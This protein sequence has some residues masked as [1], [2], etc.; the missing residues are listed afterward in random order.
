MA[1]GKLSAGLAHELNNPAAAARRAAQQL[2]ENLRS[3]NGL[4]LTLNHRTLSPEQIAFLTEFQHEA[5]ECLTAAPALD[6]L[7]ESEREEKI[8]SWMDAH[9]VEDGWEIAPTFVRAGMDLEKLNQFADRLGG[10]ALND[11][12]QWLA[13]AWCAKELVKEIEHSAAR[14]SE[15]VKAIKEYTYM[16]RS[17]LQEVDLRQGLE[18][19]LVILSHKLKRGVNV[20]RE[21]DDHLPRI[22][23]FGGALNQIWT[24]LI[25][26][27]IDA[28][29]GQGNLRIRTAAKSDH[30]LVEIMDDGP[31]IP[32]EI[33][34][35]IF[36]P[37]F[38]T[39]PQGEGT[40]LGLDT[41]YRIVRKHHGEIRFESKPG[42]TC[43]QVRLPLPR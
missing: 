10:E 36:E 37:F 15:L 42:A 29:N 30:V 43:F 18:N 12:L 24:N 26:N 14:I 34:G 25:D 32:P 39:K 35:R 7:A 1:L 13:G 21:Y 28:M 5:A 19:T 9:G 31:G 3:L 16:D 23:A 40:G 6:P 2:G 20:V 38:T 33:Q 41:V 8:T 11:A 4:C 17:P 27:A 22:N